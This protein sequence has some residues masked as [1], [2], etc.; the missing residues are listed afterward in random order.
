MDKLNYDLGLEPDQPVRYVVEL[1][2]KSDLD[3]TTQPFTADDTPDRQAP[4]LLTDAECFAHLVEVVLQTDAR[5]T[6]LGVSPLS[7]GTRLCGVL[8]CP[9]VFAHW[10]RLE[11]S[12][13]A[14]R[15]DWLM[16]SP[17]SWAVIGENSQ[18]YVR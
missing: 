4:R 14:T 16:H 7:S 17:T 6:Q 18:K 15:L 1:T 11:H 2:L 9:R 13:A 3:S 12:L 8:A 10:L 5:L